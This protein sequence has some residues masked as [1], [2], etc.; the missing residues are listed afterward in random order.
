[1]SSQNA[2]PGPKAGRPAARPETQ[3]SNTQ[4]PWANPQGQAG[5]SQQ[6]HPDDGGGWPGHHQAHQQPQ[7]HQQPGSGYPSF[8]E[9]GFGGLAQDQDPSFGQWNELQPQTQGRG[10]QG[11]GNYAGY[12]QH[13][14]GEQADPYAPQFEPYVPPTRTNFAPQQPA[15]PSQTYAN[16]QQPASQWPARDHDPHGF[17]AGGYAP[18]G[19]AQPQP[20]RQAGQAAPSFGQQ[21]YH[22][23]ELSAADW[24][25]P[26]DNFGNDPHQHNR[27]DAHLGFGQAD[28]GELEPAYDDEDV[29]YE[30]EEETPRRRRPLM[31]VAALVGAIVVGGGMAYGYKTISGG[32]DPQGEPPVIKSAELPA[33]TKPA[34]A[35]GRQF[36][37]SDTKIM[38]RLGDGTSSAS[39]DE[40]NTSP[41]DN[42]DSSS[43]SEDT[44]GARKVSTLVVG[45]DGSILV[46]PPA[47]TPEPEHQPQPGGTGVPGTS[48]IDFGQPQGGMSP[49]GGVGM[50]PPAPAVSAP[51]VRPTT[52]NAEAASPPAKKVVK[53]V[54]IAKVNSVDTTGSLDDSSEAP[55]APAKKPLKKVAR[56]PA[57]VETDATADAPPVVQSS[58]GAG[59]VA[60]LASV[61]RSETSRIDALKTFADMQQKYGSAL[62]GKTPDIASATLSKGAYDRLVVGPPGSRE[63]ANNVCSQLKAQ[64]YKDCWVTTY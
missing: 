54:T 2:F 22:D 61:P 57:A 48:L 23:T 27:G 26:H 20:A 46:P 35:G 63:E 38:G 18:Q 36:P 32:S 33:R 51:P 58:G 9:P 14:A 49:Q 62:A 41:S 25:G 29:E 28:G 34:D 43:S 24:A 19:F 56:A 1:M 40:A 12:P 59:F 55:A 6:N 4:P 44:G 42:A 50:P 64:G 10:S 11:R 8:P 53:P 45:R 39:A 17:D 60:V 47:P 16:Q 30:D 3:P 37:Y 52:L 31:I 15:Q 5:R 7:Q 13:S 21:Q